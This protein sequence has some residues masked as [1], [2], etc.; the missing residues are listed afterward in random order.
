MRTTLQV[1]ELGTGVR[2]YHLRHNRDHA[3]TIEGFVRRP[4]HLF[5][6]RAMQPDVIGIGRVLHDSMELERHLPHQYG[7]E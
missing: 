7:D 4:R 1:V 5:L 6:Y 3:R 2:T